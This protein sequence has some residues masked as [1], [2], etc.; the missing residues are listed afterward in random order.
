MLPSLCLRCSQV[1]LNRPVAEWPLCDVML[2][3]HSDGFPL[4]RA[5][6]YVALRRPTLINDILK[7]ELLLDRRKVY[8][9][10]MVGG[11]GPAVVRRSVM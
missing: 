4:A 2:S 1:I 3:W 9:T 8:Q 11:Q 7:Q 6:E 10:L 5:K